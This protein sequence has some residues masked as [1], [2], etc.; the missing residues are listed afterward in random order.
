MQFGGLICPFR[1]FLAF[2]KDV[3]ETQ[4]SESYHTG[5]NQFQPSCSD[6]GNHFSFLK[7]NHQKT[8]NKRKQSL[9]SPP[10][11]WGGG[12]R[13]RAK[14]LYLSPHPTLHNARFFF[15]LDNV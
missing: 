1:G 7:T 4:W 5:K 14:N 11:F 12:R 9:F 15:S 6:A 13:E 10:F 3:L 8:Q 2:Q